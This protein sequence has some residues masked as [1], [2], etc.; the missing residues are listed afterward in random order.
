VTRNEVRKKPTKRNKRQKDARRLA[1]TMTPD[2][3]PWEYYLR[4]PITG[5]IILARNCGKGIYRIIKKELQK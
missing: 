4:N 5:T 1:K 3:A 2:K